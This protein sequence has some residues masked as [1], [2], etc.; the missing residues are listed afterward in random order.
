MKNTRYFLS[1]ALS[2]SFPP[3]GLFVLMKEEDLDNLFIQFHDGLNMMPGSGKFYNTKGA[4]YGFWVNVMTGRDS[5]KMESPYEKLV[6][7]TGKSLVVKGQFDY[8]SFDVTAQYR[9]LI[10]NSLLITIDGMGHSIVHEHED[11][12]WNNVEHFL[13][14]GKP[15]KQPYTGAND[16]WK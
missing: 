10:P 15:I 8:I 16:P 11:E 3:K 1:Q 6:N 2:M 5:N 14:Y 4:G 13:K 7:F 12:I 9:D